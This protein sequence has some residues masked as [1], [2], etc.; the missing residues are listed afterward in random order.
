VERGEIGEL[1]AHA[2]LRVQAALLEHVPDPPPC[3]RLDRPALPA[4]VAAVGLENAQDDPHRRGLAGAV[5]TDESEHLAGLD[6]EGE[7]VERDAVPVALGEVDDLETGL[8]HR[9]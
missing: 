8:G 7:A 3:G 4:H 6:G 1:I 5:R 9:V 2:H